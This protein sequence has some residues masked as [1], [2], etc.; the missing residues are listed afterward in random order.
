MLHNSH[1]F[2]KKLYKSVYLLPLK[3][4]ANTGWKPAAAYDTNYSSLV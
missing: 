3:Q 4:K 2:R 1:P